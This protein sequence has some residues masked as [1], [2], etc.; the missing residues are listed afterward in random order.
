[1]GALTKEEVGQYL[2]AHCVSC[3]QKVG[4]FRIAAGQKQGG[5]VAGY[6]CTP[7]GSVL[8][9][10][11]GPVDAETMLR[12]A[13]WVIETYKLA[14]LGTRTSR[15]QLQALFRKAHAERLR[16]EHRRHFSVLPASSANPSAGDLATLLGQYEARRLNR[17][18]QVH[19]LLASA[20]LVRIDQ[21]YA[22]VF[23]KILNERISTSPVASD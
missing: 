16:Q 1:V 13:R 6:F 10:L 20:T 9:I 5:N 23:E 8:H 21:I 22:L 3:F 7:D 17:Q 18:G 14:E 15:A 19:L 4:T 2:N 12:E 11:A